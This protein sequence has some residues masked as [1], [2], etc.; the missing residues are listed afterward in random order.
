MDTHGPIV[1]GQRVWDEMRRAVSV[2]NQLKFIGNDD[3]EGWAL[4]SG[5]GLEALKPC[6]S[7]VKA[8]QLSL[9]LTG[10]KIV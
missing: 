4:G 9:D 5:I 1:S 3:V 2:G 7:S 6:T 8:A 10:Q